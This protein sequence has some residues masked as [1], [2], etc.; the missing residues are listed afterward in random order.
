MKYFT[1]AIEAALLTS[2]ELDSETLSFDAAFWTAMV[3]RSR[4]VMARR[5]GRP[6]L[7]AITAR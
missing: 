7:S 4:Y 5:A 2:I 6:M 3:E 1:G